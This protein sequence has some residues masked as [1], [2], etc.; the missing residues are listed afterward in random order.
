MSTA[1]PFVF[2]YTM[3]NTFLICPE[4]MYRRYVKK[5]LEFKMTPEMEFGNEVHTAMEY[6]L[7]GKP[8]PVKMQQWEPF[9][10]AL[11]GLKARAEVKLGITAEGKPTGF[12][13]KDVW[14]RG[15]ADVIAIAG[16]AAFLPDWKT[17]K[18]REEPLELAVNA[19]LVHA[20]NPHLRTFTGV[21]AWLKENRMGIP[22]DVSD[23]NST[24]AKVNNIV[25]DIKDSMQTGDWTKRKSPLCSWCDVFDCE[26]NSNPKRT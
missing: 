21:Y 5:D 8:L 4:Q 23:T 17:G 10:A 25:E 14:L 1:K 11:D 6:R 15:K 7:G 13:D 16:S 26:Y 20:H 12:F 9:A 2:T 24:W 19:M 3:I 22:H 18:P